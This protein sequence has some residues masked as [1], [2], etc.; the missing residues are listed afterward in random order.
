MYEKHDIYLFI[1]TLYNY[2][3]YIFLHKK[4]NLIYFVLCNT[5]YLR[6]L[7]MLDMLRMNSTSI[8]L[9]FSCFSAQIALELSLIE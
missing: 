6:M 4:V 2:G 3:I 7:H 5:E 8:M 9:Y 1:T